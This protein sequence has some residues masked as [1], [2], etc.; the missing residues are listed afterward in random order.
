MLYEAVLKIQLNSLEKQLKATTLVL[1][2]YEKRTVRPTFKLSPPVALI[3]CTEGK[4]TEF[5]R[6]K[7]I[8]LAPVESRRC[9]TDESL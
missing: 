8:S 2:L 5:R 7:S 6:R 9:Q 4:V 3:D 1:L